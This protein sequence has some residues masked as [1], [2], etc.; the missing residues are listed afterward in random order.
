MSNVI[1]LTKHLKDKQISNTIDKLNELVRNL[2]NKTK[3]DEV[4]RE[5]EKFHDILMKPL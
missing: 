3:M 5:L 2:N 4:K 1:D